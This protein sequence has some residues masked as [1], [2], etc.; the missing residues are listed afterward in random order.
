M[1][2][3]PRG[4]VARGG[5]LPD[6]P[7]SPVRPRLPGRDRHPGLHPE[8]HRQALS[9]RLRRPHRHQPAA[10]DLR[11]R[12]SAGKSVRGGV[13]GR[14]HTGAS[15]DRPA[16]AF[17]RRHGDQG[18]LG[19]HPLPRA[20][21]F[22]RRHRRLGSGRHG[23]RGGHG[24]GRMRGH[25]LRGIPRAGR[26]AQVRHPGLPAA[27]RGRRRR[28]RQA[29]AARD[30]VR[31]QHARRPS[32]HGRADA[33]RDGLPRGVH[34][35]RRGL[36]EL[37]GDSG[38]VAERGAVGERAAHALQSH[39]GARLSEL[40]HAAAAGEA[41]RR[42]RRRQHRD[43]RDARLPAPRRG[44][45]A[46]HLPPDRRPRRRRAPRSFTTPRRRGSSSTG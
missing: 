36:S 30:Q 27:E 40:R 31:V 22:P 21:R 32:L 1:R 7:R 34:R 13:H 4:S 45:G 46:L 14:R 16:R 17:R 26:R 5:P 43:G 6:V 12:V 38:R 3:H 29:A 33:E 15:G 41:G 24:E 20:E 37:H 23:L 28:D 18:G 35:D 19:G 2:L 25:G 39:A 42:D 11:P 9:R 10:R 44:R 8:D